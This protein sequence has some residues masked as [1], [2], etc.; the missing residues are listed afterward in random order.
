MDGMES[1][2]GT[3]TGRTD[4][5][6]KP[7]ADAITEYLLACEVEAKSPR[8]VQAYAETLRVFERAVAAEGLPESVKDYAAPEIYR[9]LKVIS[10]RPVSLGT[11]HRRFRE[12]RA[13]FS[14]C[15]RMGYCGRNPFAGI[16]NVRVEQ[17]VIQP[18]TEEEI[19][20]LLDA[21]D[22]TTE[23]GSR[24]RAIILLFLDTGMRAL[25]LLRVELRDIDWET[26]RI[27]VR[28]GKGRKQRVAP[29]GDGPAEAMGA[30]LDRFR[31]WE[32]GGLFLTARGTRQPLAAFA[33]TTLFDRLGRRAGV[34]HAHA[35]RFRHTFAT[36]AIENHAR[37][38]DV[39]Y[40]L[41]HSTSAMVRRYSATY[42][43]AKAAEA[44]AAF[45]P[46]ARLLEAV[47]RA[48]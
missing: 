1:A 43:A 14:W 20:L 27:H 25:E 39:Q 31:G 37:E 2:M 8:T 22:P 18:F 4:R 29:F 12:T 48:G 30:Y 38:L 7:L 6:G 28:L 40:L 11:R 44:H 33:L 47:G 36:W 24:N 34:K 15:T 17:K 45:S 32:P 35:H 9:F 16:P 41:G 13:F 10:D 21:S 26:R 46:A 23:F 19:H 42:D 3:K 5:V